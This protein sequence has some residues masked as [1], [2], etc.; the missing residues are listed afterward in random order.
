M[1]FYKMNRYYT[2]NVYICCKICLQHKS[3]S[4]GFAPH[5]LPMKICRD[6][7]KARKTKSMAKRSE[8]QSILLR[9]KRHCRDKGIAE[10]KIWT[11]TDVEKLLATTQLSYMVEEAVK[12]GMTPKLKLVRIDERKLFLPTNARLEL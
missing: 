4:E 3:E 10:A 12:D 2:R 1:S 8:A 7:F 6:C 5:A 11:K 9:F